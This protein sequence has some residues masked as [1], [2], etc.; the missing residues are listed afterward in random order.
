MLAFYGTRTIFRLNRNW[1]NTL[2]NNN[3]DDGSLVTVKNYRPP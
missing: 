1:G 2:S 3:G